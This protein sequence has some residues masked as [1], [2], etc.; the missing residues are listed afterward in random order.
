MCESRDC[1]PHSPSN[2]LGV[3]ATMNDT[4]DTKTCSKCKKPLPAT[5][6][7]FQADKSKKSGFRS[8][9]KVCQ[10]EYRQANREKIIEYQQANKDRIVEYRKAN[11]DKMDVYNKEYYKTNKDKIVENT[12]KYYQ[13]NRDK[14]I[15][16][17]REYYQVNKDKMLEQQR[18]Y[19]REYA[20]NNSNKLRINVLR[21]RARKR[22]LPDT[23]TEQQWQTCLEYFDYACAVCGIEFGDAIPHADHW[24]PLNSDE[25]TG[26]IATNMVCLCS[27]CNWSKGAKMPDVWLKQKYGT[28]KANEIL[29][30]VQA[31]FEQII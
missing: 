19:G 25:C 26:T 7:Y 2:C 23:L 14:M 20:K 24:I 9:C 31:Y 11:K 12:K 22:Q 4:T 17:K 10:R 6:E 30:R 3:K 1:N 27:M 15:E 28:R 18:E 13:D 29:K 5:L 21:R 16:K 8:Q